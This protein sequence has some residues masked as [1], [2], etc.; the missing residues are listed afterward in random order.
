MACA[1]L[2]CLAGLTLVVPLA[3]LS[4]GASAQPTRPAA[5]VEGDAA[6]A[7]RVYLSQSLAALEWAR[8]YAVAARSGRPEG[9]DLERYLAELGTITHG[10]ERY[11]RPEGPSRGPLTP[12]EITGQF[13]LDGLRGR[14]PRPNGEPQP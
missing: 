14:G 12:V 4:S 9:F 6:E 5:S 13:L 3:G 11:L 8:R 7:E 1:L 2:R 10:L